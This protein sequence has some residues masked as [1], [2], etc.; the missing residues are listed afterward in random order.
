MIR[1]FCSLLCVFLLTSI[2]VFS[3][4]GK[5]GIITFWSEDRNWDDPNKPLIIRSVYIMNAD[6]SSV[7]KLIEQNYQE[8]DKNFEVSGIFS[9]SPDCLKAVFKIVI[10]SKDFDFISSDIAII[11]LNTRKITN[12][13]NGKQE[14]CSHPRWSPDGS[15]IVFIVST[16]GGKRYLYTM[17]SDGSD[18]RKLTDG[19]EADWSPDGQKIAFI[20]NWMSIYTIKTDGSNER[21]IADIKSVGHL[22]NLRWS[23]DGNQM[24]FLTS[25]GN[26][27]YVIDSTGDNLMIVRESCGDGCCWSPGG[28]RISFVNVINNKEWYMYLVGLD[29]G[30][31]ERLTNN[32]RCESEFDWRTP[33]FIAVNSLLNNKT[34]CWG[35]VKVEK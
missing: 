4:V 13:T 12:L 21:K 33:S 32:D 19:D 35:M 3:Q 7:T 30:K 24:I 8:K 18:V 20:R 26:D 6:G 17:N 14:I 9:L 29:E 1:V 31:T 11:D 10:K 27:L 2:N 5:D 25:D 15:K 23:P 16:L 34:I 28:S 22:R